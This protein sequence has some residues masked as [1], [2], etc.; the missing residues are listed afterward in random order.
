[1]VKKL[2]LLLLISLPLFADTLLSD[3]IKSL[4]G[5]DAYTKN[6]SYIKI[7]FSPEQ[8]YYDNGRI[9]VVKV[10]ETL[11]ENGLLQLFFKE[12]QEI[13]L[14][15]STNAT[16]LFFVKIIEDTLQ[17]MGYYKYLVETAKLDNSEFVWKIKLTSEYVMDPTVLKNEL[18]K[19]ES[20]L[21]DIERLSATSWHYNIDI[22]HAK[23]DAYKIVNHQS[24]RLPRSQYPYWLDVAYSKRISISS[25]N[26][27]NWYPY[28]A[29][30]DAELR[31][32][33]IIK[34]DAI[35]SD[36]TVILPQNAVYVKLDDMY[37][38]KN[39]KDGFTIAAK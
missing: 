24:M 13:E 7:I 29:V 12:P 4:I 33:D 20:Y 25:Q 37:S 17:S 2:V 19:R 23:L 16:A 31:L 9:N 26:R 8:A 11:K 22:S 27:N 38:I 18:E 35:M 15:F 32:L 34:K 1:M 3:K 30:Y 6:T 10:V 28:I 5:E 21:L 14:S 39:I 36:I